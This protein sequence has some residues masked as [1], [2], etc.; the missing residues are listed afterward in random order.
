[1]YLSDFSPLLIFAVHVS[2][3]MFDVDNDVSF[4][5][6]DGL[7]G[8]SVDLM[9]SGLQSDASW[10][11]VGA[12][13]APG[14]GSFSVCDVAR[15]KCNE[16]RPDLSSAPPQDTFDDQLL[17]V[18]VLGDPDNSRAWACAPKFQRPKNKTWA[19]GV[20]LYQMM[21]GNCFLYQEDNYG[22]A[23]SPKRQLINYHLSFCD[24]NEVYL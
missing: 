5:G 24:S 12:P 22:F 14:G 16:N 1:M 17:G 3:F 9:P 23:S 2:C 7:F 8:Y 18:A 15:G 6:D 20:K 4:K 19:D 11:L 13:K 21:L 10:L